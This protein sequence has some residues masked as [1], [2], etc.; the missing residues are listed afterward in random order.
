MPYWSTMGNYRYWHI[1]K[2]EPMNRPKPTLGINGLIHWRHPPSH[3]SSESITWSRP[4]IRVIWEKIL[5]SVDFTMLW[6]FIASEAMLLS[7][8]TI[9]SK[10]GYLF[11]VH[12]IKTYISDWGRPAYSRCQLSATLQTFWCRAVDGK[13]RSMLL[14]TVDGV[15]YGLRQPSQLVGSCRPTA[16]LTSLFS[17]AAVGFQ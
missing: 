10:T 8:P 6:S 17:L 3:S 9:M 15:I 13:Q 11:N 4:L 14:Q 7:P 5:V 2:L 16:P 12:W 1:A